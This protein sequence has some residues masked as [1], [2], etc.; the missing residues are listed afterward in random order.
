MACRSCAVEQGHAGS[1]VRVY[2]C[3]C[4]AGAPLP[5]ID[6]VL[7]HMEQVKQMGGG[8]L[9]F[10]ALALAVRKQAGLSTAPLE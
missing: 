2:A 4:C 1:G 10:A 5:V 6:V 7:K 9:D 3:M 8:D